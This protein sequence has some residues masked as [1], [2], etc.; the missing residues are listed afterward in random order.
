VCLIPFKL[1]DLILSTNPVKFYE[2]ISSGKPVVS[3]NL[4]E[5][6]PYKELLYISHT[7]EEFVENIETALKENNQ[8]IKKR[9]IE[10]ARNNDWVHRVEELENSIIHIFPKVSIIMVTYNNKEYTELCIENLLEKTAYPNYELIIVDNASCD[11]TKDYL[12]SL[13]ERKSIIKV[14]F[15]E[16]NSGFAK[17]NNK[18]ISIAEG[19]YLI[20]IN[21]DIIVTRGW[22]T[23]LLKYLKDPDTGLVGPVTNSIGNESRINYS[24]KSFQELEDFSERYTLNHTGETLEMDNLA[25]FCISMRKEMIEKIGLLDEQFEIGMFEDD[26]Y[27]LRVKKAGYKLLCAE[28]VFIHHFGSASF[29]KLTWE[30]YV[31]LSSKNLE[32]FEQKWNIKPAAHKFRSGVTGKEPKMTYNDFKAFYKDYQTTKIK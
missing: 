10:T 6:E 20:F 4:P 7:K 29:N 26:D 12:N 28:D 17:G 25:F 1:C 11:E 2:Y 16:N 23:G 31:N 5:L 14:I 22:V 30:Q 32:R 3:T 13:K 19:E 18:G 24:Y 27:C 21:N 9:R 8:E 15:N